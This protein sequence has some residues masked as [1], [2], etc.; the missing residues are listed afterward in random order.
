M[1]YAFGCVLY[2]VGVL[3]SLCLTVFVVVNFCAILN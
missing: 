2:E 1:N 3:V